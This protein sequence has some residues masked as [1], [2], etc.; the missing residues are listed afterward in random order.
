MQYN[1]QQDVVGEI[2]KCYK[3]DGSMKSRKSVIKALYKQNIISKEEFDKMSKKESE[4][5]SKMK[6]IKKEIRDVEIGKL[7]EQFRQDGKYKCF[8]WVQTVLLKACHAKLYFEK[9]SLRCTEDILTK[10]EGSDILQFKFFNQEIHGLPV[11]S[12]VS[13]HSLCK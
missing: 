4:R 8:Q 6:K 10:E 9:K 11:L 7:C 1:T 3:E 5:N 2:V 13:Y 12:P